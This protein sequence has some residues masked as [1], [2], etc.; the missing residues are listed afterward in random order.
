M[1]D[2]DRTALDIL[3]TCH[4]DHCQRLGHYHRNDYLPISG[5]GYEDVFYPLR[6]H[7]HDDLALELPPRVGGATLVWGRGDFIYRV[8][9]SLKLSD[10][11]QIDPFDLWRR[12]QADR[13]D[14]DVTV[15]EP[16]VGRPP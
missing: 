11:P 14:I 16:E 5:F 4:N 10:W 1:A 2:D 9:A 6:H 8:D 12:I 3:E 15:L 7:H 13:A